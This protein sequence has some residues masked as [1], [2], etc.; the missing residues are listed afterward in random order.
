MSIS[1]LFLTHVRFYDSGMSRVHILLVIILTSATKVLHN[2]DL[3]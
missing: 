3:I 2:L 1:A